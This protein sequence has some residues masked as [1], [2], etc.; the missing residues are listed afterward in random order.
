MNRAIRPLKREGRPAEALAPVEKAVDID[1]RLAVADPGAHARSLAASLSNLGKRFSE[2]GR[3]E[4]A[5][6]AEQEALEIYRR[7]AAGNP[8]VRES[9]LALALGCW[10]WVRY[11]ARVELHEALRAIEEALRLYDKLLPLAAARYVPDRAEAL[12]LQAN[13]LESLGRHPEAEDI[14]GQLAANED[15]P[16]SQK[17]TP[18]RIGH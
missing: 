16:G 10:A 14:P 7:L 12:R 5:M 1:R 2:L 6:A 18:P 3:R 8:D 15:E 13:L 9:D 17:R 11:E 4:E